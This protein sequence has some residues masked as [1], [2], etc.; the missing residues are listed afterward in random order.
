MAQQTQNK[1]IL[2]RVIYG[3]RGD[4]LSRW[5]LINGLE[6]IGQNKIEVFAHL[7]C[8]LPE[9]VRDQY[10]PY[11]KY[12]NLLLSKQARRALHDSDRILWGGG[13][14]ITDESS[15][16]K[17]LYLAFLFSYYRKCG[18]QIDCVF[19]GAGPVMTRTGEKLTRK[20]LSKVNSFIARDEYTYHLVKNMAPDKPVYLAGDAIFMPGFEAQIADHSDPKTIA[21]YLPPAGKL[22]IAINIRRWFHFSS[23]L[24]PFQ[25]AKKRYENRGQQQMDQLVGIYVDLVR[26][27]RREYDARVL[28]VSAYNPGVFGWEDDMPWLRKIGAE[29]PNDTEV[30]LLDTDLDMVDYLSLMSKADLAVSMRLHSS[31][32]VLRFGNPA[33]NINYSPK[34]FHVFKTLGMGEH[35]IEIDTAMRDPEH[36]WQEVQLVLSDLPAEKQKVKDGVAMLIEKNLDVLA[37]LFTGENG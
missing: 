34:G 20:I 13:L 24:I 37:A 3:N 11:G 19:Q 33:I 26:K 6:S 16:A 18:K 30:Q 15:K 25:M 29:F 4:I 9:D 31:L 22:L 35:A 10:H 36:I 2:P 1:I 32:T 17:L 23:D 28:L 7:P 12:H 14:D 8:D 21:P 5:G 27:I